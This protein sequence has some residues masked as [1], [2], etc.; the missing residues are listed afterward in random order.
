MSAGVPNLHQSWASAQVESCARGGWAGPQAAG[1]SWRD[2]LK[3]CLSKGL[4][5]RLGIPNPRHGS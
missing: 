5:F 2:L 1:I 3:R 4:G